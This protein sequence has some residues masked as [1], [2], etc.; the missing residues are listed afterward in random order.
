MIRSFDGKAPEV[1]WEKWTPKSGKIDRW[2]CQLERDSARKV[3]QGIPGGSG[4][5]GNGREAILAGSSSPVVPGAVNVRVLG[6]GL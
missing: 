3:H 2:R 1:G 4:E 5:T 6:E